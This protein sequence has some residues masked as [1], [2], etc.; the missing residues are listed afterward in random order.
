MALTE[1]QIRK[2][3]MLL[4]PTP[5]WQNNQTG[6]AVAGETEDQAR[7]VLEAVDATQQTIIGTIVT[8]F[9]SVLTDS[10]SLAATGTNKGFADSGKRQRKLLR[11]QLV[12]VLSYDP[13]PGYGGSAPMIGRG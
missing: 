9:D 4:F 12:S 5:S 13:T 11:E 2:C 6:A 8:A 10:S 7:D 1:T 3:L